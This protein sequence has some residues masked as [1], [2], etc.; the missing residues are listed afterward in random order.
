MAEKE[1]KL[2][3]IKNIAST[4]FITGAIV[5]MIISNNLEEHAKKV[6]RVPYIP[7]PTIVENLN[8]A[9]I[10]YE[11]L[12]TTTN[13]L[14]KITSPYQSTNLTKFIDERNA[15]K[16]AE[17]SKLE[18]EIAVVK[19]D[20]D[21]MERNQEVIEYDEQVT[22]IKNNNETKAQ[23]YLR[24]SEKFKYASSLSFLGLAISVITG[25]LLRKYLGPTN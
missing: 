15:A 18:E 10:Y 11:G 2:D 7:V 17:L 22:R 23:P 12:Q 20:I 1:T 21:D 16:R 9:K 6:S 19:K 25:G 5:T 14:V 8:N 13:L 4:G 3:K 24:M